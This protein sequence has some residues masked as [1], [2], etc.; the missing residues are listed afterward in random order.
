MKEKVNNCWQTL[1]S[2]VL[3]F[4]SKKVLWEVIKLALLGIRLI[5]KLINIFEGEDINN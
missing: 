5:C 2:K 1:R 4:F 3:A